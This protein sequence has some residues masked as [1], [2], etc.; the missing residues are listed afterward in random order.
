MGRYRK[1][2]SN[3]LAMLIG[4][5]SSRLL[6]FLLVP[7]YTAILTTEEYGVYDLIVTTVTLLTPFLTLAIAEGVIR[8]CL[9]KEYQ[10]K[11]ILTIGLTV[12][13]CGGLILGC[14]FPLIKNIE[15][16]ADYYAWLLLF[17]ISSN[18]YLVL[19]QYLKGVGKI[20]LYSGCGIISTVITLGLDV[21]LLVVF[22]WG[23]VGYL[24]AY[25]IGHLSVAV[26]ICFAV[27]IKECLTNPLKIKKKT[28]AD[29]LKYTCPMIPNSICWWVSNSS[30]KYMVRGYMSASALGVYSVSYKIPTVMAIFTT[31]FNSAWQISAVDD[32]GSEESK[33]FF[34][35][36]YILFSGC[37]ILFASLLILFSKYIAML[38][39]QND[40]FIAWKASA[41]LIL[42][43]VFNALAGLLGSIY[44]SA[45]KTKM[46][47]IS[48]VI[49]AIVNIILNIFFIP[50]FGIL[51]A[52]AATFIS[53][54]CIWGVRVIHSRKIM[55]FEIKWIQNIVSYILLVLET[56]ILIRDIKYSFVISLLIFCI[57]V[58]IN[59]FELLKSQMIK[60]KIQKFRKKLSKGA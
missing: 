1:L 33:K 10:S 29:V 7:L 25:V 34:S 23:I 19:M 9:D 49:A 56:C 5:F 3:V 28:Y 59:I 20:K 31:I 2:S 8:F 30:D 12:V 44:T 57:I 16:I 55:K 42:A 35:N 26:I 36:I 18:V 51:G 46:L 24:S 21:L 48:T 38:L 47:F 27:N 6:S 15:A 60:E 58:F 43:Y 32:F 14:C 17:F 45:K 41:I 50:K 53:Y 11:D 4:Q 37:N 22:S 40:F 39:Y 52:A 54:C 13:A